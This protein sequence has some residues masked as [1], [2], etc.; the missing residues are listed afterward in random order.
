MP[1]DAAGAA[2]YESLGKLL[3]RYRMA[4]G[5]TQEELA[6]QSGVSARTISSME[7]GRITRPYSRSVRLIAGA[8]KLS[9]SERARFLAAG[10]VGRSPSGT[11]GV[12]GPAGGT[13]AVY[14]APPS[15][16]NVAPTRGR[17]SQLP[18]DIPEFAG[19]SGQISWLRE[20]LAGGSP[21]GSVRIAAV[22]GAGGLGKSALA[23]HVGHQLRDEFPD[24]QLFIEL[25][26]SLDNPLASTEAL[27]RLL[28]HLGVGDVAMPKDE[29]E[30]AAEYRTRVAD[31]RMLIILDDARDAAHARP[32]LPGTASGAVLVTS[33]SWLAGLEGSRLLALEPLDDSEARELFAGIC[34]AER[35]A[36]EPAA[37]D[38]VLAACAGLPLAVRIAASRLVSRPGGDI[39]SLAEQL[40]DETQRLEGL[41]VG[42]L[43]VRA[44]FQVS[45]SALPGFDGRAGED[46]ARAFRLLG[47]WPGPDISLPA[48]AALLGLETRP[49]ARVLEKLVD[50]HLLESPAPRRY[51]FHDLVRVFAAECAARDETPESSAQAILR[52]LT[53]YLH[54]ADNGQRI[55]A[56]REREREL[57]PVEASVVPLAFT[58]YDAAADWGE[59]ERSKLVA[60][61]TL[62]ARWGLHRICAQLAS[63]AWEE[64]WRRPWDGWVSVLQTG[65]DSA[66]ASG[67][68][69]DRAWL[70]N[71]LGVVLMY[72]GASH[73]AL[74]RLE[75]ALPLSREVGDKLCEATITAHLAIACKQLKRYDQAIASFERAQRIFR[76]L[77]S[78]QKG[79]ILMNLGMLYVE[80][81]RLR[82]G[83]RRMEN[84]LA[85][86][87]QA[88]N[89]ALESLAHSQLAGSYRQLGRADDAI[90]WARTALEIS[91]RL[92][93]E[94]QQTAAWHAL[95][96]ALADA[97]DT[98]QAR[99]CL[100]RA[101]ALAASL[102]IPQAA[103]IAASLAAL[104]TN[105]AGGGLGRLDIRGATSIAIAPN[106]RT[107][108]VLGEAVT[109]IA[110]ATRALA[111]GAV[112]RA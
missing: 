9:D 25:Q 61:V 50:I 92:R 18:P 72:Q 1:T 111:P 104:E 48:T 16:Q 101:H 86:L 56:P 26:G 89:L 22:T 35:P 62:A 32:L 78:V 69:A 77:G 30:L 64:Y 65:I 13:D 15:S 6:A 12:A 99:A 5:L 95:G 108:Y 106:G 60:A 109:P 29:A 53:W 45:Y 39:R 82:E 74:A 14:L 100:E 57:V 63:V 66:T 21:A 27:A 112:G 75:A 23:V 52:L 58:D 43:A 110:L 34:G 54:T 17:P 46:A 2:D 36:A 68:H 105:T 76:S 81:G 28:R 31:R 97:G 84:A 38:A 103:E 98:A 10:Y 19:R 90:R 102:G 20:L 47:L 94:Y 91:R 80:V 33:R 40:A 79:S 41:Q 55:L 3:H 93:D 87:S 42:D 51:R 83:V 88:G 67:D 59:T 4:S 85:V 7:R 8:L 44:T 37:T 24:G 11:A 107:A 96:E 71:Y 49:T 73:D 70:L